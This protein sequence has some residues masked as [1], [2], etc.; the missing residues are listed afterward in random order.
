MTK[1]SKWIAISGSWR[2]TSPKVEQDVKETVKSII[3]VGNGIVTGGAL[4]VDY[5]AADEVLKLKRQKQL[6]IFLPTLLSI[7]AAH[8]RKRAQE[9]V[10]TKQQAENLIKQLTTFK[11]RNPEGLIE[12][13]ENTTVNQKT[14]FQRNMAIVNASDEL[15]AFQINNSPGVKDTI[16]KARKKGIPVKVFSY[17]VI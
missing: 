7:Y 12:N 17:Q 11:K 3:L 9:N 14:Y 16:E 2:T 15:I 10:I 13:L 6:K 4:N 8:Y 5:Q 1:I